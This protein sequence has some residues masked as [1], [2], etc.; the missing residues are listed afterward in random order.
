MSTPLPGFDRNRFL[1]AIEDYRSKGFTPIPLCYPNDDGT[2][3][4]AH[5]GCKKGPSGKTSAGKVPVEQGWQKLE[6]FPK[7]PDGPFNVGLRMGSGLFCLE[8][9]GSADAAGQIDSWEVE[10]GQLPITPT[11]ES[12]GGGRHYLLGGPDGERIPNSV[13][14]LG[15]DIDGRG[16]GGQ[17]VAAP[18]VH[19]SGNVYAWSD[20]V[21]PHRSAIAP[22]PGWLMALIRAG[23]GGLSAVPAPA[24]PTL[25]NVNEKDRFRR[26]MAYMEQMRLAVPGQNGHGDTFM[27]AQVAGRG[28]ALSEESAMVVMRAYNERLGAAG[29]ETWTE[30]DLKHKVQSAAKDSRLPHGYLLGQPAAA[31]VVDNTTGEIVPAEFKPAARRFG[32]M[33]LVALMGRLLCRDGY[34]FSYRTGGFRKAGEDVSTEV[35][36]SWLVLR[37]KTEGL[38]ERLVNH[39]L[40]LLVDAERRKTVEAVCA[41]VA[42]VPKAA[43]EQVRSFARAVTGKDDRL[44]IAVIKHF[45]WQVKRKLNRLPVEHHLMPIV[46]GKTRGGKSTAVQKLLTPLTEL[47]GGDGLGLNVL[48]DE[49]YNYLLTQFYVMVFDEM[50][51]AMRTD[52]EALKSRITLPTVS[53][54]VLGTNMSSGGAN[55]ATFIGTSEK[56][57]SQ[58]INDSLG[59]G[60]FFQLDAQERLDWHAINDAD[61]LAMWRSVD[62]HGPAPI[63]AFLP[64][65]REHQD[66]I[67]ATGTV[68]E[69]VADRLVPL[70]DRAPVKDSMPFDSLY[71]LYSQHQ[72]DQGQTGRAR[73]L[74]RKAFAADMARLFPARYRKTGGVMRGF[75]RPRTDADEAT[76]AATFDPIAA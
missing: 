59:A 44:V 19:W 20:G 33:E 40:R 57:V 35:V 51:K 47:V 16:D 23:Q 9:E 67:K 32:P 45:I 14:R 49:R 63:E 61:S 36:Q 10:H 37:A 6:Y 60:R 69:F 46:V 21:T 71:D 22:I 3:S 15:R 64:A 39:T 75:W 8:V 50:D 25:A 17:I 2:C 76:A 68:E 43:D 41:A 12:G 34:V 52:V 26:A 31:V 48:S 73:Q 30:V 28:F 54:R 27:V 65:L 72:E 62:E 56:P 1:D 53:W 11:Q 70:S 24:V 18:S 4:F 38:G 5:P 66:R 7:W 55:V 13:K 58:L 74:G 42:Y 29:I